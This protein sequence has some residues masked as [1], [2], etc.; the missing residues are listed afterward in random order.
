MKAQTALLSLVV[1]SMVLEAV[2][3]GMLDVD[4]T[5]LDQFLASGKWPRA[6]VCLAGVVPEAHPKYPKCLRISQYMRDALKN[7]C[8][9]C[10][11]RENAN[12][13]K[14]INAMKSSAPAMYARLVA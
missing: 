13:N 11:K 3:A 7:R 8:Q 10:S 1:A 6:A 2:A 5:K 9:G 12:F 4:S 14:L